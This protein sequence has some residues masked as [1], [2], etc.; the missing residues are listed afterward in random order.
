MGW[1]LGFLGNLRVFALPK[2]SP[3]DDLFPQL[4]AN[5]QVPPILTGARPKY[6][7]N[8]LLQPRTR[9]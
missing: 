9:C 3:G 1:G 6:P 7:S 2:T 4:V 5:K 8:L